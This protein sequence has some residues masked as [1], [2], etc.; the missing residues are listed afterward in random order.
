MTYYTPILNQLSLFGLIRGHI[1]FLPRKHEHRHTFPNSKLGPEIFYPYLIP[2]KDIKLVDD[3]RFE[4]VDCDGKI[5]SIDP[6]AYASLYIFSV[7]N[8]MYPGDIINDP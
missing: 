1:N 2:T 6:S 3:T 4:A 5:I 7:F 8:F